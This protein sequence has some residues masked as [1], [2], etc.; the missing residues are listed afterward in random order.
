M[1]NV[2]DTLSSLLQNDLPVNCSL[3]RLLPREMRKAGTKLG[4]KKF[5]ELSVALLCGH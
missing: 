2:N 4:K 3:H 5:L 1:L